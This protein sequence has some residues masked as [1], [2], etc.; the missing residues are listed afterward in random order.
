MLIQTTVQPRPKIPEPLELFW[1]RTT[2]PGL[3][4]HMNVLT[5]KRYQDLA[6][7]PFCLHV[8]RFFRLDHSGWASLLSASWSIS[9]LAVEYVAQARSFRWTFQGCSHPGKSSHTLLDNKLNP[10]VDPVAQT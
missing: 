9:L 2:S 8:I 6:T 1:G 7:L 3:K 10:A 5:L 4:C